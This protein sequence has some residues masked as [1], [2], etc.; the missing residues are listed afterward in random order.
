MTPEQFRRLR[1]AV[2]LT[3]AEAAERLGV[4]RLSVARYETGARGIP[5]P[6]ARLWLRICEHES[7]GKRR[8]GR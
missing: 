7:K 6:V 8:G 3:Q 2:G 4:T 5:E 1:D